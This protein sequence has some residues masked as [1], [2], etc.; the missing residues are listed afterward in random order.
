MR[1]SNFRV[2]PAHWKASAVRTVAWLGRCREGV[3]RAARAA[4]EVEKWRVVQLNQIEGVS[5]VVRVKQA[6]RR[7]K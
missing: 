5:A 1:H 2:L 4:A 6:E 3:G 7:E